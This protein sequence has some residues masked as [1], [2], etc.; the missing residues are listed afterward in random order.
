[1]Y[2]FSSVSSIPVFR[3]KN[4]AQDYNVNMLASQIWKFLHNFFGLI[5]Q[6]NNIE[7]TITKPNYFGCFL[8]SFHHNNDN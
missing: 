8:S 7:E 4:Y 5:K 3:N 2:T 1:M 6:S